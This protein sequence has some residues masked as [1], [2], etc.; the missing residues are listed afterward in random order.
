MNRLDPKVVADLKEKH[1][2]HVRRA[3][4]AA[5]VSMKNTIQ[6][7]MVAESFEENVALAD[8][9]NEIVVEDV[10]KEVKTWTNEQLVEATATSIAN[11]TQARLLPML[12]Q[13]C[14]SEGPE[15][16][17]EKFKEMVDK[18]DQLLD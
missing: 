7:S 12:A 14:L 1:P 15:A 3:I 9:A 17:N 5:M 18:L 2:V 11:L 8:R 6:R 10:T 4:I 16:M 13:V